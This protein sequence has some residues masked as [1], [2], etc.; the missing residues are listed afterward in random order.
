MKYTNKW[1][2]ADKQILKCIGGIFDG[3]SFAVPERL[4]TGDMF[5]VQEEFELSLH[6]APKTIDEKVLNVSINYHELRIC[7]FHFNKD[8]A[9]R[10]LTLKDWTDRQAIL[11]QFEK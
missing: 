8:E 3:Q 2:D 10:F 6:A 5:R 1:V 11:H 7:I 9:Y 4:K